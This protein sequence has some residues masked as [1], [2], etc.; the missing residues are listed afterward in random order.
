MTS[1]LFTFWNDLRAAGSFAGKAVGITLIWGYRLI[2]RPLFPT[3]CRFEPS[4]SEYAL[5]AVR[6]H[7]LIYGS[8]LAARRLGRCNPWG[9][10]GYDPV[11]DAHCRDHDHH[12][13]AEGPHAHRAR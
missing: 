9:P 13:H 2:I 5:Q 10:W 1:F 4:C 12:S 3:T 11:P 8:W 6:T 7:G